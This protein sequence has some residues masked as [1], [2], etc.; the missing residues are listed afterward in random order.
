MSEQ[1][2]ICTKCRTITPERNLG[3]LSAPPEDIQTAVCPHCD[4]NW[5]TLDEIDELGVL[6]EGLMDDFKNYI[7]AVR[8][9]YI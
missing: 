7:E 6:T 5:E 3:T 9:L 8:Q 2:Y 4:C 1:L